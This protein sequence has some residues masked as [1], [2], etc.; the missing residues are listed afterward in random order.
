MVRHFISLTILTAFVGALG[1][2][3]GGS[4]EES[5]ILRLPQSVSEARLSR[6]SLT[7][8][9]LADLR[10]TCES[11]DG[12][13]VDVQG[14]AV[15]IDSFITVRRDVMCAELYRDGLRREYQVPGLQSVPYRIF[16]RDADGALVDFGFAHPSP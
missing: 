3:D 4:V 13:T 2:A 15:V 5:K 14:Q 1:W 8:V 12:Y 9:T 11:F 6:G 7:L 10:D 16:F